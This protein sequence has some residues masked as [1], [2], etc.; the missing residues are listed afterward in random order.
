MKTLN[1]GNKNPRSGIE[2]WT[3]HKL[4][5][6]DNRGI[7]STLSRV[8]VGNNTLAEFRMVG[9]D[10]PMAIQISYYGTLVAVLYDDNR[11]KLSAGGW[12]ENATK[13]RLDWCLMPIGFRIKQIGRT[14]KVYSINTG[15]Y[16]DYQDGMVVEKGGF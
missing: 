13:A 16:R 10:D 3:V 12:R 8:G 4:L 2:F 9:H 11:V 15:A 6:D 1:P 7:A 5:L 14:W